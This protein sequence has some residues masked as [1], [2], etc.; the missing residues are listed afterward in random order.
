MPAM[1]T[2]QLLFIVL[3]VVFVSIAVVV[4]LEYFQTQAV[5]RNRDDVISGLNNLA[6]MAQSYYKKES[7]LGGG[8]GT[9]VGFS[10]PSE[11]DTTASGTYTLRNST[12]TRALIQ[13][14]GVEKSGAAVGCSQISTNVTYQISVTSSETTLRKVY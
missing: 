6:G 11:L 13:G 14:V 12:T 4:G 1:G 2:Q 9:F 3:G 8:G 7:S 10:I 5:E